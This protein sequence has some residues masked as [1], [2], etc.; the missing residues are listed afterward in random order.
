MPAG[1]DFSRIF[2]EFVVLIFSLTV[3]EAAHAFTSDRLGDPTARLLGRVSLNPAV[4]VDPI[5]TILFPLIAMVTNVP[6]LGWAKPVPVNITRLKGHW[7]RKYML[8]AAA[9]PAS[10]VVLAVLASLALHLVPVGGDLEAATLAPLAAFL[11]QAVLLNVLLAVFNMVPV[12][13]LD[14]GNVLAGVLRGPIADAYEGLRPYGF[15]ILYGLMFTGVLATIISPPA[16]FLLS[17]LL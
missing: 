9:G 8:I 5:G 11:Y 10:N 7:K 2:I 1:L 3:H 12:P 16:Q 15:M 14:G 4:H 13:P 17:L 6:V